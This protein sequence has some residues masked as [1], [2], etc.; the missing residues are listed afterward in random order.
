MNYHSSFGEPGVVN[1]IINEECRDGGN[2]FGGG[3]GGGGGLLL[4]LALAMFGRGGFGHGAGAG[5]AFERAADT[6][7]I[8]SAIG[9]SRAEING[10]INSSRVEQMGATD[11]V[12]CQVG[13]GFADTGN[14][15]M[16]VLQALC[17]GEKNI[18]AANQ[19][20]ANA[21]GCEMRGGFSSLGCE[22]RAGFTALSR[23]LCDFRANTAEQF[24]ITRTENLK[25]LAI[26]KS[27]MRDQGDRIIERSNVGFTVT[28]EKLDYLACEQKMARKELECVRNDLLAAI[29]NSKQEIIGFVDRQ[30]LLREKQE[31]EARA[32]A[33]ERRLD[34]C[35]NN[36]NTPTT[37]VTIS[38]V[39]SII[40]ANNSN[41]LSQISNL[42]NSA[43]KGV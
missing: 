9:S 25:E 30:T 40:A 34:R 29:C 13:V 35:E 26:L 6:T 28:G 36:T 23:D 22:T 43:K 24:G 15:I 4:L 17:C 41:L 42:I 12:G 33:L 5:A 3:F 32:H 19:A 14:K 21:L 27:T 2:G 37:S 16:Q 38:D 39:N 18:I 7:D 10:A 8:L 20:S 1:K 11:R 31:A